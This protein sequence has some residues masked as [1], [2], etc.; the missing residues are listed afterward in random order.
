MLCILSSRCTLLFWYF[1]AF[2]HPILLC[3]LLTTLSYLFT[4]YSLALPICPLVNTNG[5]PYVC[6]AF[7]DS[8]YL[9]DGPDDDHLIGRNMLSIWRFCGNKRILLCWRIIFYILFYSTPWCLLK[10]LVLF[11]FK[12]KIWIEILL[13]FDA[14]VHLQYTFQILQLLCSLL[15]AKSQFTSNAQNVLHLNQCTH[16]HVC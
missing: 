10:S 9:C 1:T 14:Q 6:A 8:A 13:T 4:F 7:C 11:K 3:I 2:Y 16:G 5:I 12:W 15:L